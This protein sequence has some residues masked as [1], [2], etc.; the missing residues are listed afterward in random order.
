MQPPQP[1]GLHELHSDGK[2]H[3]SL[4]PLVCFE[5]STL[6]VSELLSMKT[7][8]FLQMPSRVAIQQYFLHDM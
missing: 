7:S 5:S 2:K 4:G 1:G 6:H 3:K 8:V